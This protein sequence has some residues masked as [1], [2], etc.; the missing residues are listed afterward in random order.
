M[1]YHRGVVLLWWNSL[2]CSCPKS[3]TLLFGLCPSSLPR[4]VPRCA[5]FLLM[6]SA[7]VVS[8][9]EFILPDALDR[10]LDKTH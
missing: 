4:K 1:P 5:A 7:I 2:L 8:F 9:G 10:D 3:L 6:L